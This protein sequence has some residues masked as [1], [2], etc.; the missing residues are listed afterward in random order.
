MAALPA[1]SFKAE[2]NTTY[3]NQE[4]KQKFWQLIKLD[5]AKLKAQ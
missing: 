2:E 1:A 5:T 3:S 4:W